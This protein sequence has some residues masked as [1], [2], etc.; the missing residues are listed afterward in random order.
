M[1]SNNYSYY[2]DTNNY[3]DETYTYDDQIFINSDINYFNNY[4]LDEIIDIIFHIKDMFSHMPY[5]LYFFNA[6][7]LIEFF[8]M[9]KPTKILTNELQELLNINNFDD[10]TLFC[11]EFENEIKCSFNIV[12]SFLKKKIKY[13]CDYKLWCLFCFKYSDIDLLF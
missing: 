1:S 9:C 11:D 12:N 3:K 6:Q 4:Y 7:N 13:N 5:F 10:Y 2:E 8:I